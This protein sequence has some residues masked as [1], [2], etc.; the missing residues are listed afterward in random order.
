MGRAIMAVLVPTARDLCSHTLVSPLKRRA[1]RARYFCAAAQYDQISG[2]S[3][4][5][6]CV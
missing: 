1:H 3:L 2:H 6:R 5:K 4:H